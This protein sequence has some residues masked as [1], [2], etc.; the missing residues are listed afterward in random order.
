MQPEWQPGQPLSDD[1]EQVLQ[2]LCL[3]PY[4]GH[5]TVTAGGRD[6]RTQPMLRY[7]ELEPDVSKVPTYEI[8]QGK[9]S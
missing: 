8:V 3:R 7:C 1:V 4:V 9:F 2:A 6:G 5:E